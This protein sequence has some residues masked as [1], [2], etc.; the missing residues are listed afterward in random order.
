M[1]KEMG[2]PGRGTSETEDD[3]ASECV[4]FMYLGT[5]FLLGLV[6]AKCSGNLLVRS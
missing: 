5:N 4:C 3:D 6:L 2:L 1:W